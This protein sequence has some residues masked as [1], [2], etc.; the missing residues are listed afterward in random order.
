MGYTCITY[1]QRAPCKGGVVTVHRLIVVSVQLLATVLQVDVYAME[2]CWTDVEE[3][4]EQANQQCSHDET[5]SVTKIMQGWP[6]D[7]LQERS[8][9]GK[10]FGRCKGCRGLHK[11]HQCPKAG[12]DIASQIKMCGGF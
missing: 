11:S 8:R 2:T 4:K 3:W 6:A 7:V 1:G 10:A 5:I 12:P 9:G